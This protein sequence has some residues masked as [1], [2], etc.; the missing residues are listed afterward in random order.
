MCGYDPM[1]VCGDFFLQNFFD[2]LS[3]QQRTKQ[4]APPPGYASVYSNTKYKTIVRGG[5][6]QQDMLIPICLFFPSQWNEKVEMPSDPERNLLL[7]LLWIR[8]H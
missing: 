2:F 1:L 5:G 8:T 4:I 6:V 3:V 7:P